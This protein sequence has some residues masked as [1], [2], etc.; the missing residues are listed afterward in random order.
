MSLSTLPLKLGEQKE[1]GGSPWVGVTGNEVGSR[2][3]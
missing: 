2:K 3:S 1:G